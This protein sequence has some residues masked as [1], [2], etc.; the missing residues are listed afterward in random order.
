[1]GGNL[2]QT[3]ER[4]LDQRARL[5]EEAHLTVESDGLSPEQIADQV[6]AGL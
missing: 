4:M 2:A 6:Q 3:L 1:V 5:Y